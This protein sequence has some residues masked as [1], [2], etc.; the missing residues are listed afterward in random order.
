[1]TAFTLTADFSMYCLNYC[2]FLVWLSPLPSPQIS[3]N[4][5]ISSS[6]FF[7]FFD[8]YVDA[9]LFLLWILLFTK[10]S[11][12]FETGVSCSLNLSFLNF[13]L[14]SFNP[15]LLTFTLKRSLS[16]NYSAFYDLSLLSWCNSKLL[17][18]S[19]WSMAFLQVFFSLI[20]NTELLT[21]YL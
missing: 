21:L 10:L 17:I 5:S 16:F 7:G 3:S 9:D 14:L 13:S 8:T 19:D 4:I 2:V 1:M 18:T 6:S 20:F 12:Y 11:S 15:S